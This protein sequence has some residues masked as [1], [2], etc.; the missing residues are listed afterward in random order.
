MI[1]QAL[2]LIVIAA[3]LSLAAPAISGFATSNSIS[4]IQE[5][6]RIALGELDH[7]I[8]QSGYRGCNPNASRSNAVDSNHPAI[9]ET[10]ATWAYGDYS[11]RGFNANELDTI[12]SV[13]GRVW[14]TR[15]LQQADQF[16]GDLI[17]IRGTGG[18]EL[19]IVYHDNH[20]QTI[21]FK[22]DIT[23]QLFMGQLI[24]LN[25]CLQAT[26]LQIDRHK[27]P[28]YDDSRDVTIVQYGPDTTV[29]CVAIN[30]DTDG[31]F[32]EGDRVLLGG[33]ERASCTSETTRGYF[34]DYQFLSGTKAHLV[35]HNLYY[36]G[37]KDES[38]N[39][40]LYR[41]GPAKN[42]TRIYTE[43]I[44]E[45]VENLRLLYGVDLDLNGTPDQY[46]SA[47]EINS[48]RETWSRLVSVR[49]WL[50][51][52][53]P[54]G[55]EQSTRGPSVSFPNHAGEMI[56]CEQTPQVGPEICPYSSPN[57]E[58]KKF[59]TRRVVQK[60]IYLRNAAL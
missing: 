38:G 35:T 6:G 14:Q 53:I 41:T 18:L 40:Y 33:D 2:G 29:N 7:A 49:A 27:N 15:R 46:L 45:G 48:N 47:G 44:V 34:S 56:S 20:A 25:D 23:D 12:D 21:S 37:S 31:Y 13:L 1:S 24:E 9:P 57:E 42:S 36:I 55:Y 4:K 43:A 59:Y 26:T 19:D 8:R 51:L 60:E 58:N 3:A 5:S 11:I 32:A 54:T 17:M 16:I 30:T 39:S 50:M 28:V 52:S 22:G 10:L